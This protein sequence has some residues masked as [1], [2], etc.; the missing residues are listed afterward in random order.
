[1][2]VE[3]EVQNC[4]LIVHEAETAPLRRV[5]KQCLVVGSA[6]VHWGELAT[7]GMTTRRGIFLIGARTAGAS[8]MTS[9]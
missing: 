8:A 3:D 6:T 2:S 5:F 4:K 1:L 9:F 7:E